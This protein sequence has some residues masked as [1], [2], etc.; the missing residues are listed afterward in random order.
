MTSSVTR[1]SS[2]SGCRRAGAAAAGARPAV[3]AAAAGCAAGAPFCLESFSISSSCFFIFCCSSSSCAFMA[4]SSRCNSSAVCPRAPIAHRRMRA[5]TASPT[6][7]GRRFFNE[8]PI[9]SSWS[10]YTLAVPPRP[11]CNRRAEAALTRRRRKR[12]GGGARPLGRGWM[13][14]ASGATSSVACATVSVGGASCGSGGAVVAGEKWVATHSAHASDVDDGLAW[15]C[16]LNSSGTS[17]KPMAVRTPARRRKD[18]RRRNTT[19]RSLCLSCVPV[20]HAL[21][22]RQGDGKVVRRRLP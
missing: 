9:G 3:P 6:R 10:G 5:T 11:A 15:P 16:P 14:L 8:N 18:C 12:D 17:N 21:P 20:K 19:C 7:T 22:P 2:R 4:L 1:C 13:R